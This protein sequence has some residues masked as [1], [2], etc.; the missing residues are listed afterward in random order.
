MGSG[1]EDG[2]K[3]IKKLEQA[4]DRLGNT[5]TN[6]VYSKEDFLCEQIGDIAEILDRHSIRLNW[7]DIDSFQTPPESRNLM[8]NKA[9]LKRL[10]KKVYDNPDLS[11]WPEARKNQTRTNSILS[12]SS[13][14]FIV[15]GRDTSTREQVAKCLG[16]L[17][18]CNDDVVILQNQPNKGRYIFEKFEQ[19]ADK[20]GFAVVLATPDDYA[21]LKDDPQK[22]ERMRQNVVFE[23]GYLFHKL[24]RHNVVLMVKGDVELPSDIQGLAYIHMDRENWQERLQTEMAD[25]LAERQ[26]MLQPA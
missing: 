18:G 7:L 23:L 25:F 11:K 5:S 24:K 13:G 4:L 9:H 21:Q 1:L 6:F 22:Q 10:W 26:R 17:L 3:L 14:V 15:H 16:D 8:K 12:K 19:E 20:C 2:Q